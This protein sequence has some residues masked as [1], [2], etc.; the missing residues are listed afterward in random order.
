MT[1]TMDCDDVIMSIING[2]IKYNTANSAASAVYQEIERGIQTPA[3]H[4]NN[5]DS[6][7][8]TSNQHQLLNTQ[9]SLLSSS[10]GDC[11]LS[12]N[13]SSIFN[14]LK[15]VSWPAVQCNETSKQ[16]VSAQLAYRLPQQVL[17]LSG[18][19]TQKVDA[20]GSVVTLATAGNDDVILEGECIEGETG[21]ERGKKVKVTRPHLTGLCKVCGDQ[22][23]GMY[24]GAL[25]CVP[26]KTFFL[27]YAGEDFAYECKYAKDCQIS[28]ATR[29]HCKH[30]RYQKCLA[31]GMRRRVRPL[32]V[33]ASE[34]QQLCV[35]CQDIGNG[36]HFG[37][38]TCEG[39]KKFFRRGLKE[40]ST[41]VCKNGGNCPINPRTRNSCRFCRF[42]KC[43]TSGMS[44]EAIQMGRP[45]KMLMELNKCVQRKAE[46]K[47]EDCQDSQ[48]SSV[49]RNLTNQEN[50]ALTSAD[51][52]TQN[53]IVQTSPLNITSISGTSQ[54][55]GLPQTSALY[56]TQS[57]IPIT[58]G[59]CVNTASMPLSA[60]VANFLEIIERNKSQ[61]AT[62]GE[63]NN[64]ASQSTR[65]TSVFSN[66][67]PSDNYMEDI[68][69]ALENGEEVSADNRKRKMSADTVLDPQE[70]SAP[71]RKR[72]KCIE[73]AQ[74]E[75]DGYSSME[76]V[77]DVEN[78]H[79]ILFS[80]SCAS[81]VVDN[82]I[83]AS[84]FT[85]TDDFSSPD[86][87][88]AR[89]ADIEQMLLESINTFQKNNVHNLSD[90]AEGEDTK[91]E[92]S[93]APAPPVCSP[94]ISSSSVAMPLDDLRHA[95]EN[96]IVGKDSSKSSETDGSVYDFDDLYEMPQEDDKQLSDMKLYWTH[97]VLPDEH[98]VFAGNHWDIINKIVPAYNRFVSLGT[99]INKTLREE[100]DKWWQVNSHSDD[101]TLQSKWIQTRVIP[102]YTVL[103]VAYCK[104]LPEF[105]NFDYHDQMTI[106]RYGQSPSRI[107]VAALHWYDSDRKS[108]KN[109]LC[110]R[111]TKPGHIDLFKKMLILYSDAVSKLEMDSIEAALLNALIIIAAD[112]PELKDQF[113]IEKARQKILSTFQAYIT[114][115]LGT[116]NTRLESLFNC[117]PEVRRL[118]LLHHHMTGTKMM[119]AEEVKR[120]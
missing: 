95:Y 108:F 19:T 111:G 23:S 31:A 117:I 119:T 69:G 11:K 33:E 105:T 49:M 14:T 72:W 93:A 57:N 35:V 97:P 77:K 48:F 50:F 65:G 116:P 104:S 101:D 20:S 51:P 44:R 2:A 10:Q 80:G 62:S 54:M 29:T 53:S 17:L 40:H 98:V 87:Q 63:N 90:F 78:L 91:K 13:G 22:A 1:D 26:C 81:T 21:E 88:L 8:F 4:S 25:V 38:V 114:A 120:N 113:V 52:F 58:A 12:T 73:R 86:S 102:A 5:L 24:F 59:G 39:C 100:F 42:K 32:H 92:S 109:F 82:L 68:N 76:A 103:S 106:I 94:T 75:G 107:L 118:G 34:G 41:Y 85:R 70:I 27:R 3:T 60:D 89:L 9:L 56:L 18:G 115:K 46:V 16:L 36:I 64:I 96:L 47:T 15:S 43:L 74:S 55:T 67:V 83:Q 28:A 66:I 45:S 71:F 37:A 84:T 110:W 61:L 79:D 6:N 30:C 112:Y 7:I 99:S